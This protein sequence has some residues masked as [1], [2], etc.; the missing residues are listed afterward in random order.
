MYRYL[1]SDRMMASSPALANR[2]NKNKGLFVI[3]CLLCPILNS[4]LRGSNPR[5]SAQEADALPAELRRHGVVIRMRWVDTLLYRLSYGTQGSGR[6]R[7][8]DTRLK[9][10]FK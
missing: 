5:P 1:L 6:T 7:T 10:L 2:H 3:V 8:C 9:R 4:L